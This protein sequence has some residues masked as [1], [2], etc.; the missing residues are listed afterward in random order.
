MFGRFDA[1][2]PLAKYL[3]DVIALRRGD[4]VLSRGTPTV[5]QSNA[6]GPGVLAYRM[7]HERRTAIVAFNTAAHAA[8]LDAVDTGL[9]PGTLLQPVGG[10]AVPKEAPRTGAAG[11]LT[12]ELPPRSAVAWFAQTDDVEAPGF[13]LRPPTIEPLASGRVSGDF[14]VRG[15]SSSREPLRVVVDDDLAH[16]ALARPDAQGRWE[17]RVD[18]SAMIDPGVAPAVVAWDVA[19]HAASERRRFCV[20]R[21]WTP[22]VAIDD[23]LGDDTGPGGTYTYPTGGGYESRQ[24]D[25]EHV[26]VST[27]G[28]ALQVAVRMR[29]LTTPWNPPNGF[30]HVAFNVFVEVPGAKDGVR[31]MPLLS[32]QLP[33]AMRWH[34]R[35][36]AHGWSNAAFASAGASATNEG[37]AATAATIAS[38]A[39]ARTVTF[40]IPAA[41]LGKA[42]S[43]EGAR[44]YV[45][46]WDYDGGWR[47]LAPVAAP[48]I[49]G[50]GDPARDARVLDAVGPLRLP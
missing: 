6:A 12:F 7:Q 30:D 31:E 37:A 1:Q 46:T 5:L 11:R 39:K 34:Y 22:A 27:S 33:D 13:V 35:L 21:P 38:D 14:A 10:V 49:F 44:V 42:R 36:R 50:G 48:N 43:L 2:A 23:P 26:A 25:I 18:T 45:S 41:A 20:A 3:R 9:A 17:A 19:G 40:T 24:G 16:A 8:L 4:K 28:G 29:A 32:A 47:A 15:T